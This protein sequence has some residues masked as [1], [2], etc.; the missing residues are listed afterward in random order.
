MKQKNI[1]Q[2]TIKH[3]L[4]FGQMFFISSQGTLKEWFF[5]FKRYIRGL[6]R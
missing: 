4:E 1:N 2:N 5:K 6:I 3:K